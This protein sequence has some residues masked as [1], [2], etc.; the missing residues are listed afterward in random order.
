MSTYLLDAELRAQARSAE[1]EGQAAA[2]QALHAQAND[3][4]YFPRDFTTEIHA[5]RG[6][7]WV[8]TTAVS[9]KRDRWD[10]LARFGYRADAARIAPR[11]GAGV[12]VARILCSD[13]SAE[14]WGLQ[15]PH[16]PWFLSAAELARFE[17]G[18]E[19]AA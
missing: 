13:T 16:G 6:K 5:R 14:A 10:G 3:C 7:R 4:S 8:V 12:R 11:I 19:H 2:A 15:S 9:F 1:A 18:W 17:H